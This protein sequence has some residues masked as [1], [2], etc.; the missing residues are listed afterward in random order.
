MATRTYTNYF[1][2]S[3]LTGGI[4]FDAD[5]FSVV[6]CSGSPGTSST[7]SGQ[8]QLL[9]TVPN[10]TSGCNLTRTIS[11]IAMQSGT[12]GLVPNYSIIN[13]IAMINTTKNIVCWW[14]DSVGLDPD[15]TNLV[16]FSGSGQY[17][18]NV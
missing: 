14:D 7:V 2:A 9:N 1:K 3:L 15:G 8:S 11:S 13:Y 10:T 5:S 16:Y 17:V 4:N 18:F 12:F 6:L